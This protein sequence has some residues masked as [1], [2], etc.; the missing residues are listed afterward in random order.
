MVQ[1]VLVNG[2]GLGSLIGDLGCTA[3]MRAN[4]PKHSSG[5]VCSLP[6]LMCTLHRHV[7]EV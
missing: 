2:M 7:G 1:C 3:L 6:G 4:S 5:Y